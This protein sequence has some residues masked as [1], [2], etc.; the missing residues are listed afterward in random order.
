MNSWWEIT[1]VFLL[2]TIKFVFGGVPLA[3]S[4]GFP[5][6]EAVTVTTL[7]G[8]F[9]AVFFVNISDW[10]ISRYK[11]KAATKYLLNPNLPR[12]KKFTKRNRFIIH[13]KT[14]FGLLGFSFIVPFLIPIPIGSFLAVR[15][16][17]H[18]QKVILYMFC[19]ILFWSATGFYIYTPLIN[20]I[21]TYLLRS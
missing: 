9:S 10:I 14:R 11:K 6:F 12:K 16:F 1:L 2:S 19:S 7:G 3:L 18:K 20:A 4:F 15:Y 8:F 13:V 21:R 17:H 5:F